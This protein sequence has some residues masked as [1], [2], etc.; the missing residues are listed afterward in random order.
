MP[1]P[2]MRLQVPLKSEGLRA[3]RAREQEVGI[4]MDLFKMAL[5][6]FPRLEHSAAFLTLLLLIA[7]ARFLSWG[8]N[9]MDVFL[10]MGIEFKLSE[11]RLGWFTHCTL[12]GRLQLMG[13]HLVLYP[14]SA[15]PKCHITFF[16]SQAISMSCGQVSCEMVVINE[17]L[18]RVGAFFLRAFV[19]AWVQ[20]V[21]GTHMATQMVAAIER[22]AAFFTRVGL[23][24]GMQ[25]HVS[26]KA[27]W[28]GEGPLVAD[29]TAQF[30]LH[31]KAD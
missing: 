1:S 17:A 23:I 11:E 21:N 6:L 31:F 20:G 8:S 27:R 25:E 4:F 13:A 24:L 5:Q 3:N 16:T 22:G 2:E 7:L 29:K 10:K 14:L 19:R 12:K 28:L 26:F 9:R 15:L 18:F 30:S